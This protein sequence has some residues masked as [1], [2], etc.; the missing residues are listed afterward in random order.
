MPYHVHTTGVETFLV[1]DGAVEVMS[2]S[3]KAIARKG[4]IVHLPPHTPHSIRILEDGTIWRAFHQGHS[5]IQRMIDERRLRDMYPEI[6]NSPVYKQE[7]REK[8][9]RSKSNWFDYKTPVCEETPVRD[10]PEIRTRDK[11]LAEFKLD[12]L[13]LQLVVGR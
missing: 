12:G 2:R 8:E 10:F 3:R 1:D 9:R 4:D 7:Q 11:S 13:V 5:L 6:F